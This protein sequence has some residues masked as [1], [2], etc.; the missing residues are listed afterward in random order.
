[1]EIDGIYYNL[2]KKVKTAEVTKNPSQY[3][4]AVDIPATVDY[5]GVTYDVTSIED[6]AFHKCSDLI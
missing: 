2:V 5:D 6:R 3:S 4:G 1:M